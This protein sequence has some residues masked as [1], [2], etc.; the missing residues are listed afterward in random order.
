M[1]D[2]RAHYPEDTDPETVIE[3]GIRR[4]HETL[5][6]IGHE[7][8]MTLDEGLGLLGRFLFVEFQTAYALYEEGGYPYPCGRLFHMLGDLLHGLSHVPTYMD[9]QSD[10]WMMNR[11][12]IHYPLYDGGPMLEHLQPLRPWIQKERPA[13]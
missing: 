12:Q 3:Q 13:Q 10:E 11:E 2:H 5:V 4:L 6:Q 7:H 9:A 8:T 1:M